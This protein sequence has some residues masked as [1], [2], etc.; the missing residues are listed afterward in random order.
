M[1]SYFLESLG[2][3]K[4]LVD[5]E[6]FAAIL[7]RA[8]MT[9]VEAPEDADLILVNTCS[10]LR[11]SLKELDQVLDELVEI[12]NDGAK[13]ELIVTGCVIRRAG[14]Q[15]QKLYPEVDAW[16]GLK[17]YSGLERRLG[18]APSRVYPRQPVHSGFHRYLR[19]SDGCDNH[20]SYCAIPSIRGPLRSVPIEDLVGEAESLASAPAG[21]PLELTVIAQDTANYGVDLYG[22]QALPELLE[23]LHDIPQ[24]SWLRVLY[25]HPDHFNPDWLG[26]WTRQPKL[27]P[28][29]EIPIQ[30]SEDRI[31]RAMNRRKGRQDL[32]ALFSTIIGE[33]PDAVLRT[34]VIA[35]FPG[36]TRTEAL[37]LR[38]FL[39]RFPFLHLGVFPYSREEGTPAFSL[40]DQVPARTAMN[41]SDRILLS[42]RELASSLLESYVGQTVQ[43]LV[44]E[45]NDEEGKDNWIGRAW[46]QAPEIDGLT[47][48]SGSRLSAGKICQAVVRDVIDL[49]LF[50]E[51]IPS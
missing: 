15:F 12:K 27:L 51:A 10:F 25:L 29:F 32:E 3:A 50:A 9:A 45:L 28:Y 6:R 42:H 30:H 34:T 48:V 46:F 36:E 43:V 8:G 49:D 14:E 17:D 18:L 38:D 21:H 44:E 19:V 31:L 1:K 22:R 2:C 26:L 23:R 39:Q 41:R 37:A 47:Y 4:N 40:A 16:L 20:C 11:D 24:F 33:L 7:Q 35:G 13:R 5:S